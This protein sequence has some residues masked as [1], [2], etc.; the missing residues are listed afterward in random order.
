MDN[1]GKDCETHRR[2][3]GTFFPRKKGT[4]KKSNHTKMRNVLCFNRRRLQLH[5]NQA[6]FLMVNGRTLVSIVTP[7][8]S[9][10]ENE[11]DDDGFLY[12]VYASQET[13]GQ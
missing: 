10:Y 2:D 12:M 3:S 6:F 5:P 4:A 13:F 11:K 1:Q 9:V 7:L 8:A